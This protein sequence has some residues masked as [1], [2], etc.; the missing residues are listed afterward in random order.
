MEWAKV[1][2]RKKGG[3]WTGKGLRGKENRVRG[4]R[5]FVVCNIY[6][7]NIRRCTVMYTVQNWSEGGGQIP[8]QVEELLIISCNM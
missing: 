2:D 8:A 3:R 6:S 4:I 1:G 7:C 5:G